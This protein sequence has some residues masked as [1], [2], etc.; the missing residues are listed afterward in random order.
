MELS[1]RP[2]VVYANDLIAPGGIESSNGLIPH[3]FWVAVLGLVVLLSAGFVEKNRR[4]KG[5]ALAE[6]L[7]KR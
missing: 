7:L 2:N 6:E 5:M 1:I 4:E 3:D